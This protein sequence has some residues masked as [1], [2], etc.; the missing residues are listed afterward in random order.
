MDSLR[1]YKNAN[2]LNS[3]TENELIKKVF[4]SIYIY[5]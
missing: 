3:I 2:G 5:I 4:K 1:F